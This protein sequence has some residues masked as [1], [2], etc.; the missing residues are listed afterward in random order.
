MSILIVIFLIRKNHR[1][2]NLEGFFK[3]QNGNIAIKD[4]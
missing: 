3:N 4:L 1:C 2:N